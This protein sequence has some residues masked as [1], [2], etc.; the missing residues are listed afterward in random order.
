MAA[1]ALVGSATAQTTLI[2]YDDLNAGNGI[3]DAEILS[4]GFTGLSDGAFAPWQSVGTG[5]PQFRTNLASPGSG[6]VNYVTTFNRIIALDTG[7]TMVLGESYDIEFSWRDAF[8]WDLEDSIAVVLYYTDDDTID[9]STDD[10]ADPSTITDFLVFDSGNRDS[11]ENWETETLSGAVLADPSAAGKR[12]FARFATNCQ[13]N[14]FSRVDDLFLSVSPPPDPLLEGTAGDLAFGEIFH[15][16]GTD[17]T[18]RTITFSNLG[19]NNDLTIDAITLTDDGGGIYSVSA[20]PAASTII[21]PGGTFDVE[22]TATGGGG[23]A[24]FAGELLIDV[25]PDDQDT[26]IPVSALIATTGDPFLLTSNRDFETGLAGWSG[27]AVATSGLGSSGGVRLR[28]IG[29]D[30]TDTLVPFASTLAQ[31]FSPA[32][33]PDFVATVSFAIPDFATFTSS[34]PNPAFYDRS[35]HLAILGADTLPASGIFGDA[36]AANAIINLF[37]F[38]DGTDGDTGAGF[39]LYNGGTSGFERLSALG[40]LTPSTD[41]NPDGS[42]PNTLNVYQLTLTG[43]GF[44]TPAASYDIAISDANQTNVA[45]T[46]AGLTTFHGIDPTGTTAKAIVLSTADTSLDTTLGEVP[47]QPSFW[48]DNL[49]VAL[50]QTLPLALFALDPPPR[51]HK[52]FPNSKTTMAFSVTNT[53]RFADLT[54]DSP[55]LGDPRFTL[56]EPTSF[57][58][59][60]APGESL[61]FQVAVD[62]L[63]E[64]GGTILTD[65]LSLTTNDGIDPARSVPLQ[66]QLIEGGSRILIDY[67][68]GIPGNGIHEAS[69]RNGGFEDGT[70][71]D[72][73][74][75]TPQWFSRFSPEGDLTTLSLDSDPVTGSLHG[76]TSGFGGTGERAQPA[77]L[78]DPEEWTLEAGDFFEI[79]VTWKNGAGFVE[80]DSLQVIM[81]VIDDSGNL[82]ASPSGD[83]VASRIISRLVSLQALDSYQTDT[84][85]TQAIPEGDAWI[86]QRPLLRVIK[87]GTRDTFALVDNISLVGRMSEPD[88]RLTASSVN[89]ATGEITLR[90]EDIGRLYKIQGSDGLGFSTN[91]FE[92]DVDGTADTTTYPGQIEFSITDPT[93]G[94][95][96]FWRV[97]TR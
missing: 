57:P 33:S 12:L 76:Q 86:G 61:D 19:A 62:A 79:E 14:E 25:S 60:I 68:D 70:A 37:Y 67:D 52:L 32:D 2:D 75:A 27:N 81:E 56:L 6:A 50:Q 95:R 26:T 92:A 1:L 84:L 16:T 59:S 63:A 87:N 88:M 47:Y 20:A 39:F 9:G 77:Q 31:A 90:W 38:P 51:I 43:T 91:L 49:S 96:R 3:H 11:F 42:P 29:D 89:P 54:L 4:G 94:A 7:H 44:G 10:I 64:S 17:T 97:S 24:T 41:F 93:G 48:V 40:T 58:Q 23:L 74:L 13:S 66:V 65:A 34:A 55:A 30:R 21:P 72:D 45:A 53:G 85:V 73:F 82:V 22:I 36:D 69:I 18:T 80:G 28:G 71:G 78:L 15:A 46:A 83:G 8:N 5:I 35:F